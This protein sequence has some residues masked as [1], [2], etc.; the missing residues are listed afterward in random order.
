LLGRLRVRRELCV[1]GL[2]TWSFNRRRVKRER[3]SGGAS[4]SRSRGGKFD[5]TC[6]CWDG[7]GPEVQA[8]TWFATRR[9][10]FPQT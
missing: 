1:R 3:F 8:R 5:I 7:H 6:F 4:A 10:R 9:G 2:K